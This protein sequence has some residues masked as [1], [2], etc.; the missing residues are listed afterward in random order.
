MQA[1]GSAKPRDIQERTVDYA[2]RAIK[3]YQHLQRGR[4]GASRI[5]GKQ[6]LRSATSVGANLAEASS[7]FLLK[8]GI[9]LKGSAR[10]SLLAEASLPIGIGFESETSAFTG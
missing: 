9:A 8:I 4:D 7:D 10:K 5:I 2:L 3:L 1:G 6:F